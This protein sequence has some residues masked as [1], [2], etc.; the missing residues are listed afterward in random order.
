MKKI[1]TILVLFLTFTLSANAQS[2][3]KKSMKEAAETKAREDLSELS[4]SMDMPSEKV[5]H[6]S[7]KLFLQKH[8]D[9]AKATT[10]S[11]KTKISNEV[12]AKLKTLFNERL[13]NSIKEVDG[14]YERLIK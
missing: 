2:T 6:D 11:E 5:Y 4:K 12:E 8:K 3:D 13:I 9:L 14:L 7:Y 1:I 10:E